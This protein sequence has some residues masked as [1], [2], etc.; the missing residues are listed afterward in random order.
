[1][2][3][4]KSKTSISVYVVM[5]FKTH[6]MLLEKFENKGMVASTKLLANSQNLFNN[7]SDSSIL[8]QPIKG[9]F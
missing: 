8:T 5:V 3:I 7:S 6:Q 2:N 4:K 1:M 9:G